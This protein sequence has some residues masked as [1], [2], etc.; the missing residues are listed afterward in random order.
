[1]LIFFLQYYGVLW[2]CFS[3]KMSGAGYLKPVINVHCSKF[4]I[5]TEKPE[6]LAAH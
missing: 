4:F 3:F 2:G 6:P 5:G 1:M